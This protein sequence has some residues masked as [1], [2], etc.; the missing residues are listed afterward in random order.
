MKSAVRIRLADDKDAG[1][2]QQCWVDVQVPADALEVPSDK[3][4]GWF[5]EIDRFVFG[6]P[7]GSANDGGKIDPHRFAIQHSV[8][9]HVRKKIDAEIRALEGLLG[10]P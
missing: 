2:A 6:A 3:P 4:L 10:K 9:H 5:E 1:K 8:L 7:Q